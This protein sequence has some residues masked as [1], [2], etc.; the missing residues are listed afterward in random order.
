[1]RELCDIIHHWEDA[2]KYSAYTVIK[3]HNK[4]VIEDWGRDHFVNRHRSELMKY[5][6]EV[7]AVIDDLCSHQLLTRRQSTDLQAMTRPE[8]KMKHLLEIFQ[9]Q[10]E[11]V[12]DQFYISLWR[13]NYKVINDLEKPDNRPRSAASSPGYGR[14]FKLIYL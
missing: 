11:S 4:D 8:D 1:M 10:S 7:N 9:N 12:K 6:T 3:N 2:G 14:T 13:H 5:V